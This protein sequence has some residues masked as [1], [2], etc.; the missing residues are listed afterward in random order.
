MVMQNS[1][2]EGRGH[3]CREEGLVVEQEEEGGA[4]VGLQLIRT[5]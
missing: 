4:V 2:L 5:P 1:P 3:R